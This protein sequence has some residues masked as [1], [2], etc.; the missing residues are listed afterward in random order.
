MF[1]L[2]G[3]TDALWLGSTSVAGSLKN[4]PM[5]KPQM[6]VELTLWVSLLSRLE[7]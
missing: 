1:P 2:S 6:N 4:T 7:F 3:G 5:Q